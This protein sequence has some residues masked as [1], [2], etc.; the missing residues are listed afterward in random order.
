MD[1]IVASAGSDLWPR[2]MRHMLRYGGAFVP[3]V[4]VRA[5]G[6][7]VYD[8]GGRRV[9]D[10]T[11]GQMSA[12]LGHCHPEIVA[13]VRDAAGRLDHLFSS[14]LSPP[15]VDLAEALA[16]LVPALPRVMLLSTGGEANEAAIKIAKL[17]TGGWE[18][19]GFAQSWHGMT[20]A[21][22]AATPS[23]KTT[24]GG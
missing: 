22:A 3:F 24:G 14:M 10:F 15:V 7:F 21:A 8:G 18:V 5:E 20:G 11:S 2:A 17:V 12:I 13:T 9:L 19:V 23:G 1:A 6:S 4:P 16:V